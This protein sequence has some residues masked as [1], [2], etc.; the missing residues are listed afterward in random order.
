VTQP[1]GD[2]PPE[3][4]V[5]PDE[6]EGGYG[7]DALWTNVWM[8]GEDGVDVPSTHAQSD[9][10]LGP[11]K[12]AWYRYVPGELTIEG[13]LLDGEASALRVEMPDGYGDSGFQPVGLIFSRAGC[14]EITGSVDGQS[15]TFVVM[16]KEPVLEST[17]VAG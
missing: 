17:P 14:W 3:L 7:N 4:V 12:W 8:W 9:G 11:M 1:N 13:R 16:V 2:V 10:S 6:F 15:L 5:D